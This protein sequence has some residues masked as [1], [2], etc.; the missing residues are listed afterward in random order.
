MKK[1]KSQEMK[2][3]ND[4][5]QIVRTPFANVLSWTKKIH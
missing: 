1:K 4:G 5:S 3:N 2:A